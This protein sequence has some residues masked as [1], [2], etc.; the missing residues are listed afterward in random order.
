MTDVSKTAQQQAATLTPLSSARRSEAITL[1][2]LLNDRLL[3]DPVTLPASCSR[4]CLPC[5]SHPPRDRVT[6]D[7]ACVC[8]PSRLHLSTPPAT[9]TAPTVVAMSAIRRRRQPSRSRG[10][11]APKASPPPR[12]RMQRAQQAQRTVQRFSLLTIAT[13]TTTILTIITTVQSQLRGRLSTC[14]T[15][16]VAMPPRRWL[17]NARASRRASLIPVWLRLNALLSF[18]R[19]GSLLA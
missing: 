6:K 8:H 9:A 12:N 13:T 15:S 18:L 1:P 19:N 14:M 3:L 5:A 7:S 17:L 11:R 10:V 16:T 2:F 4:L